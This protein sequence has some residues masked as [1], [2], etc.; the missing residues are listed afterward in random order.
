MKRYNPCSICYK[1]C[2]AFPIEGVA[3]AAK[4][5]RTE[6]QSTG[7]SSTGSLLEIRFRGVA[8]NQPITKSS[9]SP[10]VARLIK[11][12]QELNYGRIEALAIRGGL[13]VFDPP[14]HVI[15]KIKMGADNSPRPEMS[16][17]DFRLKGGV[18]ELLEIFARLQDGEIR[19]IEVRC[20]LPVSAEIEWGTNA[21]GAADAPTRSR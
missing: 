21:G 2:S 1:L 20:G 17:A 10:A 6:P 9:L 5:R 13:P 8:L 16:Y 3:W 12:L 18:V 14:P 4:I 15:Q 7:L 19:T 11:L